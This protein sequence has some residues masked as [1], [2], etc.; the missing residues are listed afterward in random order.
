MVL[1]PRTIDRSHGKINLDACYG[2]N[3]D[4]SATLDFFKDNNAISIASEAE[5]DDVL[6]RVREDTRLG[7]L[8]T[9]LE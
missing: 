3:R 6:P 1:F 5:V 2:S 4:G 8:D 7:K 9:L